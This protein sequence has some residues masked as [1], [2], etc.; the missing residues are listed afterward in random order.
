MRAPHPTC[1]AV[2][3]HLAVFHQVHDGQHGG[4][5]ACWEHGLRGLEHVMCGR[6]FRGVLLICQEQKQVP[7][8]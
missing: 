8:T 2:L 4:T 3:P 1:H 5:N 6:V 7:A